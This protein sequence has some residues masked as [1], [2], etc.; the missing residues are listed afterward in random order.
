MRVLLTFLLVAATLGAQSALEPPQVGFILD[1]HRHL[2]AVSGLAGNFLLGGAAG[3]GVVSA[4]F[5]GAFGLLKSESALLVID[6][7]GHAI[8]KGDA[9]PGPA[10]FAFSENGE[11]ALA[12]FEHTN[13]LSVWD[14]HRFRPVEL[15]AAS[16][17]A[18]AVL[19][20]AAPNSKQAALIVERENGLW[21]LRVQVASGAVMSQMA[22]PGVSAPVLRLPGGD[23]VYR[24][25][26]G[27]VLRRQDGSEKHIAAHLPRSLAFSQM[28][29]GWV[30]VTDLAS[31]RLFAVSVHPGRERYY[32]LPEVR[33]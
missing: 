9:P 28:G 23:L 18:K 10:L 31:G 11:P 3:A 27:V 30:Q 22:L 16:L 12:Y 33:P 19:T 29:E 20:I 5:S 32:V 24:D 21:E 25:T 1:G 14:G 13:A 4:A 6:K 7:R 26:H 8:A 2:R 15:D 17:A